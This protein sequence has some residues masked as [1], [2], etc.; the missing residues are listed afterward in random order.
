MKEFK[1]GEGIKGIKVGRNLTLSH[2]LFVDDII[3]FGALN[4]KE[5]EKHENFWTYIVEQ[6]KWA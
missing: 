4:E 3:L 5:V 1:K 6:I 2:L